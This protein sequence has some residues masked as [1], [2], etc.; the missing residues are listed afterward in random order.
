MRSWAR[1][2]FGSCS[3]NARTTGYYS[4]SNLCR[5]TATRRYY[6]RF[7]VKLH[8]AIMICGAGRVRTISHESLQC[9]CFE[10]RSQSR[11]LSE[12][13]QKT[14][15]HGRNSGYSARPA[16]DRGGSAHRLR[17]GLRPCAADRR[18]VLGIGA[19]PPPAASAGCQSPVSSTGLETRR[20]VRE[21]LPCTLAPMPCCLHATSTARNVS[22]YIGALPVEKIA[23]LKPP[24][25]P[26]RLCMHICPPFCAFGRFLTAP[27]PWS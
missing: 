26:W 3:C 21:A 2:A 16:F 20:L 18:P 11:S 24:T 9:L 27:G 17:S 14:L 4:Q 13:A 19:V 5:S 8:Y 7:V 22:S 15:L 1:L 23:P 10:R 6:I 25:P 12:I